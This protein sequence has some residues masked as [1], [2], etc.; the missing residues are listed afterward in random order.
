MWVTHGLR[1]YSR[2]LQSRRIQTSMFVTLDPESK[3]LDLRVYQ[4]ASLRLKDFFVNFCVICSQGKDKQ[5]KE[6]GLGEKV[7]RVKV[8]RAKSR[9]MF[10]SF[11]F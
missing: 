7:C 8:I 11:I 4:K 3:D 5:K 9:N 1:V 10:F 2:C 6:M